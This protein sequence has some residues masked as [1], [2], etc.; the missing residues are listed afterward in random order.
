MQSL[1]STERPDLFLPGSC[2]DVSGKM[3]ISLPQTSHSGKPWKRRKVD[4]LVVIWRAVGCAGSS[5]ER[6]Q[7]WFCA[8]RRLLTRAPQTLRA[9]VCSAPPA[10]GA[11]AVGNVPSRRSSQCVEMVQHRPA[12]STSIALVPREC[13]SEELDPTGLS[14]PADILFSLIAWTKPGPTCAK[15][16]TTSPPQERSCSYF[17]CLQLLYSQIFLLRSLWPRPS[18]SISMPMS[19]PFNRSGTRSQRE[20][21]TS[22]DMKASRRTLYHAGFYEAE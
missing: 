2:A 12:A 10:T 13:P 21:N 20:M 18:W 6:E 3:R 4:L 16:S 9:P 5:P 11:A 7:S 8:D 1:N 22:I 19:C 17:L 14:H 15:L